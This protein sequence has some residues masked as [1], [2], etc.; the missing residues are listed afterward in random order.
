V[1]ASAVNYFDLLMLVG[2]YQFKPALPAVLGA[3][4]SGVII[5]IGKNVKVYKVG[6]SVMVGMGIERMAEEL[7]VGENEC[8]PKPSGFTHVQ[9]AAFTVGYLTGFHGLVQRGQLQSGQT[10]LVT[11]AAGGMG[12]SAIQ[13]GVKMGAT[14]IAVVSS[15]DKAEA[16]RNLGAHYVINYL[17]QD[18]KA[19]V[20]EITKGQFV[21]VI[22]DVVGGDLFNQCVK[23]IA[24]NGRLL[25]VGFASGSIPSIPANLPLIKGFS[26]VG[27]RSGAEIG[28]N[29]SLL[30][31]I[32]K[33]LKTFT[34]NGDTDLAPL[35]NAQNIYSPDNFKQALEI[36]STR[37]VKGKSVI[38]WRP[39][40]QAVIRAKL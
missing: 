25:V 2:R 18:M 29:P 40:P 12:A 21:D 23:C 35:V 9:A 20:N 3:E 6:D 17:K 34:A 19:V 31:D 13:I 8:L 27:V 4:A 28:R 22:Y 38:Q 36:V 26:V 11:G 1:V 33:H 32:L 14:V 37:Q 39:E 15:D 30:I 7:I 10:L 5:E 24:P 16:V